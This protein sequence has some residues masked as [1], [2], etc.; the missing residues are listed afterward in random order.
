[1]VTPTAEWNANEVPIIDT[2]ADVAKPLLHN[3]CKSQ[4]FKS[5]LI[6][7]RGKI[8]THM[9]LHYNELRDNNSVHYDMVKAMLYGRY[10]II[11]KNPFVYKHVPGTVDDEFY[12]DIDKKRYK[13]KST[14]ALYKQL[15]RNEERIKKKY[16]IAPTLLDNL[17][18]YTGIVCIKDSFPVTIV[19]YS[20]EDYG[21]D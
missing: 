14:D 7:Y 9:A 20:F 17:L 8:L 18:Y 13:I 1:L 16:N 5:I 2:I 6:E 4:W 15:Q 10:K 21:N 11:K 3:V 12:R 19:P